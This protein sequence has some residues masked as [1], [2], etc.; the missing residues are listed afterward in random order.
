MI[1]ESV[2]EITGRDAESALKGG[3][4]HNFICI[5]C[6]KIFAGRRTSLQHGVVQEK[7]VHNKFVD[8][9]IICDG[10]LK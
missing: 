2:E 3:K 4:H 6:R 5:G 1:K 10:L 7:V 8:L 9:T